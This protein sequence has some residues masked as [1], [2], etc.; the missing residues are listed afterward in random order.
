M[1]STGITTVEVQV[2]ATVLS[3]GRDQLSAKATPDPL[4]NVYFGRQYP[5]TQGSSTALVTNRRNETRDTQDLIER[6]PLRKS[7]IGEPAEKKS[8]L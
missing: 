5:N 3:V 6:K 8:P 1:V 2:I 4:T 7:V